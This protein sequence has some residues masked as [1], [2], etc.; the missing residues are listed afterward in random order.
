MPKPIDVKIG[1]AYARLTVVSEPVSIRNKSGKCERFVKCK[2]SCGVVRDFSL[3][4]LRMNLT[5]SC[6]CYNRERSSAKRLSD[7]DRV[8]NSLITEYKISAKARKLEYNLSEETLISLV[9]QPCNYCGSEPFKPHRE[10]KNF[11]YNGLDRAD[12]NV[13]YLETNVVP[14][15]YI[16]NKMKGVLSEGEFMEHLNK[17]WTRVG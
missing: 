13:G 14:C 6:G 11:L 4:S 8:T 1:D 10:N 3:N 17:I 16:C 7:S 15:C 5:T 2:C 9:K 12:N